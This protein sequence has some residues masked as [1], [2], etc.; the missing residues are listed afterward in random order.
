MKGCLTFVLILLIPFLFFA[1]PVG[2]IFALIGL[3]LIL[4]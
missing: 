1:G 4:K 3:L 2:W